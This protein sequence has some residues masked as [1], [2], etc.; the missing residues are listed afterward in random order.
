MC[1]HSTLCNIVILPDSDLAKK[2]TTVSQHLEELGTRFTLKD[3]AYY[4]HVSLYMTQLKL[5]DI[6]KI[7]EVL[8][9][10]AAKSSTFQLSSQGYTQAGAFIDV[11]FER[12]DALANL[13]MTV[14]NAINPLRDGMRD[15]DRVRMLSAT[16][17]ARENLEKYGYLSV[18]ELFC[19]HVTLTRFVDDKAINIA[20]LPEPCEISGMFIKLGLFEMGDNGTCIKKIVEWDLRHE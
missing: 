10:I 11:G 12:T 4:P 2:V 3:G 20:G 14:V 15:K 1:M 13:Q 7:K 8:S 16:G 18:G 17:K 5:D 6:S 19:P 9:N